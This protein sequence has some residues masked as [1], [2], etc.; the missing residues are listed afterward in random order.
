MVRKRA[1]NENKSKFCLQTFF[2]V[3]RE[4][5]LSNNPTKSEQRIILSGDIFIDSC[6]GFLCNDA[7][8]KGEH[9]DIAGLEVLNSQGVINNS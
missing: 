5:F 6:Q 7:I 2:V 8:F 1:A 3:P 4:S 9:L